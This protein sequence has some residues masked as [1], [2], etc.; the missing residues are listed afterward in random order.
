MTQFKEIAR[1]AKELGLVLIYDEVNLLQYFNKNACVPIENQRYGR[2]GD[3]IRTIRDENQ[4]ALIS[5]DM[6]LGYLGRKPGRLVIEIK[7]KEE[8]I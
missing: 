1:R 3:T 5:L 2:E 4:E 6:V 8:G 7:R